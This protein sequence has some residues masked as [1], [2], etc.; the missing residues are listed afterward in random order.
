[1]T[2]R[3]RRPIAFA[4][5]AT[6]LL[7][8][9]S[10]CD[11]EKSPVASDTGGDVA[12]T[13]F[14]AKASFSFQVDVTGHTRVRVDGISGNILATGSPS[15]TSVTISGERIV[16]SESVA[17]AEAHLDDLQ[18]S[19]SDLGD[20]I[21]AKT[22]QPG[23]THGRNY[24][25]NYQITLPENL[26]VVVTNTNG[27]V[28]VDKIR[29]RVSVDLTNG[30]A[31]LEEIEGDTGVR[32]SNGQIEADITVP[33]DGIVEM[34][35]VNGNIV[36]TLPTDTSA[37]LTAAVT[38]GIISYSNLEFQSLIQTTKSV[39]GTLGDGRGTITLTTV[40]G[41]ISVTGK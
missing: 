29:N 25:V 30:Q 2:S 31:I 23:E 41:N 22:T 13:N 9:G 6:F 28:S 14:E 12:N 10:G 15:A 11:D 4:A 33:L 36:L 20:E 18:V 3:F 32:L 5:L 24:T 34:A 1:M 38:N 7:L 35:I 37:D 21:F 16:G 27:T 17:D 8:A 39:S 26:S 19:I 40:N